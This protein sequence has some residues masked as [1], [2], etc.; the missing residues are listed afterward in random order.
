MIFAGR[1]NERPVHPFILEPQH[2]H[3]VGPIQPFVHG[4]VRRGPQHL[5][6]GRQQCGRRHSADL[7]P[8]RGETEHVGPGDAAVQHIA[9][10]RDHKALEPALAPADGERV[11][12]RLR[13]M[14]MP[15]VAGIE[16]RAVDLVRDQRH[17]ARTGVADDDDIGGHGVERHRRVD[18]R[19]ALLHAGGGG[20]HVDD[21]RAQPL[22]RDFEGQQ[23]AGAVFEKGID[24]R[25]AG[26]AIIMFARLALVRLRPM[27]RFVQQETDFPGFEIGDGQEMPMREQRAT[28]KVGRDGRGGHGRHERPFRRAPGTGQERW[29]DIRRLRHWQRCPGQA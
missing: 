24:L 16:H 4:R 29:P 26:Q 6:L 13:R 3:H 5:H 15:A 25:H 14:L 17:R 27:V 22:A 9:A 2:H 21:I 28:G 12:Q 7:R 18:Q 19:F 10:N 23:G 11:E 8:Q 20:R 1:R